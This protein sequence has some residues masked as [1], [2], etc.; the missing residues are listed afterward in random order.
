VAEILTTSKKEGTMSLGNRD[1]LEKTID[2]MD[3]GTGVF[4]ELT[5]LRHDITSHAGM[6]DE[7]LVEGCFSVQEMAEKLRESYPALS[8]DELVKVVKDHMDHIQGAVEDGDGHGLELKKIAGKWTFHVPMRGVLIYG[9]VRGGELNFLSK[10]A[11]QYYAEMNRTFLELRKNERRITWGEL[12]KQCP[13]IYEA[14]PEGFETNFEDWVAEEGMDMPLKWAKK[15]YEKYCED[16][17]GEAKPLPQF[18][19]KYEG[20]WIDYMNDLLEYCPF[21]GNSFL[22]QR[23]IE[24]HG[25]TIMTIHDGYMTEIS[26]TEEAG[27][28][29]ELKKLGYVCIRDDY[30]INCACGII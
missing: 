2:R 6:V 25:Q 1:D 28:V 15:A 13:K 21:N 17:G 7:M 29:A 5:W 3:K 11:A 14:I 22:P 23:V 24:K 16:H 4:G 8:I 26:G 9:D 18:E 20:P 12:E 10:E 27:V 30:L 19:F